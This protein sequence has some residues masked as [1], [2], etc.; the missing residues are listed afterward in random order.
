MTRRL[1]Y[2]IILKPLND[3]RKILVLKLLSNVRDRIQYYVAISLLSFVLAL[4][5]R[6]IVQNRALYRTSELDRIYY[7]GCVRPSL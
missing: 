3:M 6:E 2:S 1:L 4:C 5:E 7:S